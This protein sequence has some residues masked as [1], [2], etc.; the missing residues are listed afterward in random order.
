MKTHYKLLILILS[1]IVIFSACK[2]E[3]TTG[4]APLLTRET[5]QFIKDVMD[6]YYL[7]NKQQPNID[8]RFEIDSKDYFKKLLY[9]EDRWSFITDDVQ[10]LVNSFAGKEKSFGWSLAFGK[11]KNTEKVFALV[12]FVYP[13]T[14]AENAGFKRGDMI[15]KMNN[16]DITVNNY[17]D[18]LYADNLTC[19]YGK[20]NTET[21][22]VENVIS[23]Q[24]I[25][26]E[27][28][29]NPVLFSKIIEEGGHKIGYFLYAQFIDEYTTSLDTL[30]QNFIY[31]G[32]TDVIVDLRYNPGGR[33]YS[34]QYLCSLIAPLNYV[35][36]GDV[37]IKLQWNNERQMKYEQNAIMNNLEK[38]LINNVPF[39]MGLDK[40][41][42]LTGSGTA[43]ASELTITGLMPYM[44]VVT[45]GDTTF[46]KYTASQTFTPE[47]IYENETYYK[48]FENW[49]IQPI[50]ARYKNTENF[51]DFVNGLYP[52]IVVHDDIAAGV[53]IGDIE[54]P[55][56]GAAV[57]DITGTSMVAK[58]S[59][60]VPLHLFDRGFSKFDRNKRELLID[61]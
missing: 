34:A 51:T 43:S 30:F 44:D 12:E 2:K 5:N 49:G 1:A 55:V 50:V 24:I 7:W 41:Y 21:E 57:E 18:L 52:T 4:Q 40:V 9:K 29:L 3:D 61:R 28:D 38:R 15:F 46:G 59:A 20:Y 16:A 31:N 10:A 53:P 36:N 27:L 45:V 17:T 58:K 23:T 42:F 37:L 47:D 11:F 32:V 19:S 35:N 39:K 48:D 6:T 25:A 54:D 33:I 13:G 60:T 26:E 8:N 22:S 14:P 56:L